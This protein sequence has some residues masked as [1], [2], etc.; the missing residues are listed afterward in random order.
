M[1]VIYRDNGK[2]LGKYHIIIVL[3]EFLDLDSYWLVGRMFS[4]FRCLGL[5]QAKPGK[6]STLLHSWVA[7]GRG[8]ARRD[9]SWRAPT[10]VLT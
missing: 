7:L 5:V 10:L 1:G 6:G 2:E 3:F 9:C 8:V 4:S